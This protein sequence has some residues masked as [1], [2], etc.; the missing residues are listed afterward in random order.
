MRRVRVLI[1]TMLSIGL[2]VLI[3][4]TVAA[5]AGS[6]VVIWSTPGDSKDPA[7]GYG[8]NI[9]H[10]VWVEGD[11]I[12]HSYNAGLGWTAP[13]SAAVGDEPALVVDR[14]GVPQLTFTALISSTTNVYHTR[15]VSP[16]WTVPIRVS[17]GANNTAAP[18]IAVAPDN[19]LSIVWSEAQ[20]LTTT[21]QIEIAES[22]NSG[23]SWP[24][25]GPI[26]DARG[27]GPRIAI[28]FDDVTHVVWQDDTAA[29][30]HI[31]HVQRTTGAWS[32]AAIVS[33]QAS[34]AFTPDV[35]A[36]GGEAHL[37]WKQVNV[38]QYAHGT[39]I[40]FSTPAA[41]SNVPA[42]EPAIAATSS[43]ALIAAWDAGTAITA[44][45]GGPGGW[46][47]EQSL[48]SNASGVNHVALTS[49]LNGSVYAVFAAGANGSRDIEFNA[50]TTWA[51]YL[52]LVL[53]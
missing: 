44:R 33:S 51:V 25:A 11:W 53:K 15:F 45:M 23:V 9:T 2:L 47:S 39:G 46:G 17:T 12:V 30:F 19:R 40:S 5:G 21:N 49:G 42:S 29:P 34:P 28:G 4:Q 6:P 1:V 38:I 22:T 48:G 8:N 27:N 31:N 35:T 50:F 37:V 36:S 24:S 7:I 14:N 18:D 20:P 32:V 13:I 26:L 3:V 52:P 10:A 43:G 41:I 16:T